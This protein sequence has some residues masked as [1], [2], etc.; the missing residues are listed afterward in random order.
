MPITLHIGPMFA[1]KTTELI[2][3][4]KAEPSNYIFRPLIDS[5]TPRY[6]VKS[7]NGEFLP[8]IAIDGLDFVD[9]DRQS[10]KRILVDEVQFFDK[11]ST[12]ETVVDWAWHGIDVHL[13]GLSAKADG[14]KWPL[15]EALMDMPN[16]KRHIY[17]ASCSVC[18]EAASYT[19]RITPWSTD[20]AIA[21]GG[22]DDYEPRCFDHWKK[23]PS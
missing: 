2:R 3:L 20:P 6:T 4:A 23:D 14:S 7:H 8:A 13:F 12:I 17:M 1:G 16:I 22:K 18:T 11:D 15:I 21:V 9:L 5:R 10:V 19:Q